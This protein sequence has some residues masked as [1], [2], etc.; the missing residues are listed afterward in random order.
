MISSSP[1]VVSVT[2]TTYRENALAKERVPATRPGN[3]RL[4]GQF[5]IPTLQEVIDLVKALEKATA[6]GVRP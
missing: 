2:G 4:D 6:P 5:E 1:V 3:A